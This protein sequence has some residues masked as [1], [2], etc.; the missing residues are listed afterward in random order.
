M[1]QIKMKI[2]K[3][4]MLSLAALAALAASAEPSGQRPDATHAWAVHDV[5]R[6]DPVKVEVLPG[7]PPSDAIILFDGTSESVVKNWQG[8]G[9]KPTKWTVKNGEFICT[10]GS[11]AVRTKEEFGDCQI[12]IEWKTPIDDRYGWGNSGV[13]LMGKYEIQILDSS[14]VKPSRSPWKPANYAD[15]QAGSVYGENPPLVQPCR[16]PGEWQT[17]DIV[18]HPPLW[19]GKRLV[20]P[21]SVTLF[22]NGVVVQD[23]FPLQGRTG[24][25]RRYPH[26]MEAK[27]PLLLQDHGHPVPFRNIW[28]RRIPS[29]Y[30]DTVNGGLGLKRGDVATLRHKLA[31]ESLA[32]AKEAKAPAERFIRLW[33]SYCY[34]PDDKV[35][36]LISKCEAECVEALKA[37]KA[38]FAEPNKLNAFRRFVNM[39]ATDG[40]IEKNAPIKK[41]VDATKSPPKPKAPNLRDL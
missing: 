20:D 6:P 16:K 31:G 17:Y 30:A 13:F 35:M 21:G 25:C 38:D 1:T 23:D 3:E 28:I 37:K 26:P 24:W 9:G 36:A 40:W 15:G 19:D 33:E 7:K 4:F 2:S 32:F 12:H 8:G 14:A 10:P 22:F 29:R 11:G 5:N 27:G 34:E 18:F 39:L 41:A